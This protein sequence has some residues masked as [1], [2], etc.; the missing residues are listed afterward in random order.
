MSGA[1]LLIK[2][3]QSPMKKLLISLLFCYSCCGKDLMVSWDLNPS[4]EGI[5]AYQVKHYFRNSI[6]TVEVPHNINN[7][8]FT[9]VLNG[10]HSFSVIAI[11][12]VGISKSSNI[13]F[14]K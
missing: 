11:N 1:L 14:S 10:I 4:Y 13:K 9:N 3:T 7:Y 12:K 2:L 6:K 5:T 8:T